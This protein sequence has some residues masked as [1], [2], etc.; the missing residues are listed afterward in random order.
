VQVE[1]TAG[2]L[3]ANIAKVPLITARDDMRD[4]MIVSVA[5]PTRA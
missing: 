2:L 1:P 5:R 4:N 3:A